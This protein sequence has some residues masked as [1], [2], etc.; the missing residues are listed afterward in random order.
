M[1]G[2]IVEFPTSVYNSTIGPMKVSDKHYSIDGNI[3]DAQNDAA[4]DVNAGTDVTIAS[5]GCKFS[6][7]SNQQQPDN[8]ETRQKNPHQTFLRR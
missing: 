5:R 1:S 8:K 3:I 2:N 6:S 4:F 7:E